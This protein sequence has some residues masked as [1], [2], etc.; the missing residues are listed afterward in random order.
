MANTKPGYFRA[1]IKDPQTEDAYAQMPAFPDY[2][3]VTLAALTAYFQVAPVN[4][5]SK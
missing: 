3:E 4:K 1:Y 5:G 2:D